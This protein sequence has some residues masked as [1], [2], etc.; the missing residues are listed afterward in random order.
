M[1]ID[2][3]PENAIP[4][5]RQRK[6]ARPIVLRRVM[7]HIRHRLKRGPHGLL[8]LRPGLT[9]QE[10]GAFPEA[11]DMLV[12]AGEIAA[13]GH[14]VY[15]AVPWMPVTRPV[16]PDTDRDLVLSAAALMERPTAQ[17][18]GD[19]LGM[20]PRKI[21][22]VLCD[23]EKSGDLILNEGTRSY[24]LTSPALRA[25]IRKGARDRVFADVGEAAVPA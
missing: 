11:L 13:M 23:L 19:W 17:M 25:Q 5:L 15:I 16:T 18:M 3:P 9:P 20:T 10:A 21:Q 22:G 2:L 1:K 6:A 7:E 4:L 12:Q 24:T 8:E 14:G